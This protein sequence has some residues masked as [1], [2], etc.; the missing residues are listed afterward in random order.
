LVRSNFPFAILKSPKSNTRVSV[1]RLHHTAFS[2]ATGSE[3]GAI[4]DELA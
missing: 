2:F 4:A 1:L 3:G